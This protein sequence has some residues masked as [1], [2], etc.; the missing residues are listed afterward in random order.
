MNLR[1]PEYKISMERAA[2]N[3]LNFAI[4]S[5]N[6]DFVIPMVSIAGKH[7]FGLVF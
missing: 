6:S 1:I 4:F 3:E 2:L 5:D 7:I